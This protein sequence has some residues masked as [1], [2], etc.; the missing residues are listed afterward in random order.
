M[1]V[2]VSFRNDNPMTIWNVLARKLG[3]DPTH[4][5]AKAKVKRILIDAVIRLAE[6]GK[7]KHQRKL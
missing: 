4:E 2:T 1:R 7:L 3:R 6:Q 5:E